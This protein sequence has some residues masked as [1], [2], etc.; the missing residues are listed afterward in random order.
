[1]WFAFWVI[2]N[3]FHFITVPKYS[4]TN[5]FN[6]AYICIVEQSQFCYHTIQDT[7]LP[8]A[9]EKQNQYTQKIEQLL[10]FGLFG[11]FVECIDLNIHFEDYCR[12]ITEHSTQHSTAVVYCSM[13]MYFIIVITFCVILRFVRLTFYCCKLLALP[14]L[15][16]IQIHFNFFF[17]LAL[18]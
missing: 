2:C 3:S 8:V 15:N 16:I 1:M 17:V 10:L 14:D 6:T 7:F 12:I 18:R 13:F 4:E 9:H 11:L 5:D